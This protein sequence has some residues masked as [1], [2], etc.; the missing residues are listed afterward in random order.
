MSR[1]KICLILACLISLVLTTVIMN[2]RME[3]VH[4]EV[5]DTQQSLAKEVFRLHE[6][7]HE[8]IRAEKCRNNQTLGQGTSEGTGKS[9]G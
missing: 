3:I 4:A 6:S 7:A 1:K 8:K 2:R 9:S 5:K